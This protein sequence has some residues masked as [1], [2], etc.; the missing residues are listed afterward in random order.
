MAGTLLTHHPA[1]GASRDPAL[2]LPSGNKGT[3]LCR[4]RFPQGHPKFTLQAPL[5]LLQGDFCPFALGG[6]QPGAFKPGCGMPLWDSAGPGGSQDS[7]LWDAARAQSCPTGTAS[8]RATCSWS[9]ASLGAV[10]TLAACFPGSLLLRR[11]SCAR[12][13]RCSL[14]PRNGQ[15][16]SPGVAW[17]S[18]RVWS[19]VGW[20]W[21]TW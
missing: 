15:G 4:R 6:K 5:L 12:S 9:W 10:A 8:S 7:P 17:A 11:G 21:R 18:L 19:A 2:L 16:A 3:S 13:P 1:A 20:H 14:C